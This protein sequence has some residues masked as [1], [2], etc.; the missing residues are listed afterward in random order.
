MLFASHLLGHL[1]VVVATL[2]LSHSI[3]TARRRS[4]MESDV[5]SLAVAHNCRSLTDNLVDA[6]TRDSSTLFRAVE[7]EGALK[8]G[9]RRKV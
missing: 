9:F 4:A 1:I 7:T 3:R 5:A 8:D 6:A 2:H